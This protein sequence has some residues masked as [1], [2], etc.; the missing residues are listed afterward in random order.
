MIALGE[1]TRAVLPM[2]N[3]ITAKKYARFNS[4]VRLQLYSVIFCKYV[5]KHIILLYAINNR[6][7][8]NNKKLYISFMCCIK[9][10]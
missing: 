6:E 7:Q 1:N 2:F 5:N 8:K 9:S 4:F 3:A 10:L